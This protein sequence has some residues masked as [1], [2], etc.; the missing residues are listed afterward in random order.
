[1]R[2]LIVTS[3]LHLSSDA[4]AGTV[5]ALTQL[6]RANPGHELVLAGDV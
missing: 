5:H 3:D 6:L 1:M 4:S 2:P